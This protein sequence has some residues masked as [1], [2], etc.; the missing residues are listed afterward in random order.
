M[1]KSRQKHTLWLFWWQATSTSAGDQKERTRAR[2][3]SR[4]LHTRHSKDVGSNLWSFGAA[5]V[6][7]PKPFRRLGFKSSCAKMF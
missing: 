6:Y 3:S 4:K 2:W 7:H 1:L 5:T